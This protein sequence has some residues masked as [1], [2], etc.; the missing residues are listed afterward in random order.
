MFGL[1]ARQALRLWSGSVIGRGRSDPVPNSF[2]VLIDLFDEPRVDTRESSDQIGS[3]QN[4]TRSPV[5]HD[6][7]V[8]HRIAVYALPETAIPEIPGSSN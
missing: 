2:C 1:F 5:V 4:H 6:D 7:R 3:I 8:L